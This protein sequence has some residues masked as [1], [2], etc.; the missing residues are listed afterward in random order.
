MSER[1]SITIADALAGTVGI[2]LPAYVGG[3]AFEAYRKICYDLGARWSAAARANLV[4]MQSVP[5][6][7]AAFGD[8]GWSVEV[9]P[10]IAEALRGKAAEIGGRIEEGTRRVAE[11]DA[12]LAGS[13]LALFAFQRTGVQWLAPR[14]RAL[15]ADEMGL[16]KTPQALMALPPNAAA[17]V[18]CPA[19]V[20]GSWKA[21]CL[22][23]RS[24]LRPTILSGVGSFRWP[25]P[26][27]V[28]ILNPDVLPP[29][30]PELRK[31]IEDERSEMQRDS[32]LGGLDA[33]DAERFIA[34]CS[35]YP[36][37]DAAKMIG[38]ELPRVTPTR[39][40]SEL[41]G[42]PPV[43]CV[44]IA[45][46]AH[47]YKSPKATRTKRF[48]AL[49]DA[50]IEYRG[51]VWLVTGTP[52]LNRPPELWAVLEAAKLGSD[53]FGSWPNFCRQFG[54]VK[55]RHG[56]D[57]GQISDE[58]PESIRKVALRRRRLEVMPS[59]PGKIRR[60][61]IV[62]DLDPSLVV[63]MDEVQALLDS[64]G[65]DLSAL[66]G[67]VDASK[68]A[69]LMFEKLS[70]LRRAMAVA[71]IPLMVELVE[72]YEEQGQPL[73]V[74]CAHTDPL[75]HLAK[76]N[77]WGL[78]DGS[79]PA[80]QRT[81]LVEDYQAG[82]LLGLAVSIAAGGVGITLTRGSQVLFV[83]LAWTPAM[84]SQAEDRVCRIGQSRGVIVTRLIVDHPLDRRVVGLLTKKQEL[85]EATVEASSVQSDYVGDYAA[86][87]DAQALAI[88]SATIA[89]VA[90][91]HPVAGHAQPITDARP[92]VGKFR[93][94][95]TPIEDHAA[96][97][98]VTL[99]GLDPDGAR[100]QNGVGFSRLDVD[101]G[102]SL[103]DSLKKYGRLSD[104][105]WR[106]ACR[107]AAKYR[108]QVG[109]PTIVSQ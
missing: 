31:A 45:D 33:E 89:T 95:A 41:P 100:Q 66:V 62:E 16:G 19:A 99:A 68:V 76:R 59:L 109:E 10:E 102:H 12:S 69:G 72:E 15:L 26:G 52:L 6:V 21:E 78:I 63:Q 85:I 74:F 91:V 105:Q 1:V 65:V 94:P 39:D 14:D 71:K 90:T 80:E 101:F 4:P 9:A 36:V 88:A 87:V 8:A 38:A 48:R 32:I 106:A 81:A 44:L 2:G 43:G 47:V 27:E 25:E 11:A 83:D 51:R 75:H 53:A 54:G 97:A 50:V 82:K 98:L 58:V 103:A 108:R 92:Q 24:D 56:Y 77:G 13:G 61:V 93:A 37:A 40:L 84:N 70:K 23:W 18:T 7:V 17:V 67:E 55:G 96:R 20:K 28:V 64:K 30:E 42:P 73:I 86:T 79:I 29:T 35:A 22:R 57:W 60:D 34:A 49:R 107:L 46:E 3:G 5:Q 104:A